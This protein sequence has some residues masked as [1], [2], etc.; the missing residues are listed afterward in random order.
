ML[1]IA[2]RVLTPYSEQKNTGNSYEIYVV[3]HLLRA[4]GLTNLQ[5]AELK[6]IMETIA[7]KNAKSSSKIMAIYNAILS[8]PVGE[9]ISYKG[10]KVLDLLN[11]T[12]SD[13][14]GRTGDVILVLEDGHQKS[15]SVC[16]GT[17]NKNGDV[18]KCITN[19]TC[20][21]FGCDKSDIDAFKAIQK[22]AV[23]HYKSEMAE[24]YG[25]DEAKWPSRIVTKAACNATSSVASM[26]HNRFNGLTPL[27]KKTI[28][29][30]LLRVEADSKPADLLCLVNK[31]CTRHLL[32]DIAGLNPACVWEPRMEVKDYWLNMYL[33]DLLIGKTQ[34]KFNNGVYHKGK[35]SSL[36]S[37]W[38]ATACMNRVFDIAPIKVF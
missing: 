15:V 2:T 8:E 31:S 18:E 16:E 26:T 37:S 9:G 20:S 19:P 35:T 32:F 6:Q 23:T 3:L 30:D 7:S 13:G 10:V 27:E 28:M 33:G 29:Q 25:S 4:M 21:R 17:K 5:H 24:K 38:N 12:Q 14:D 11:V 22:E 36:T 1:S 34:V